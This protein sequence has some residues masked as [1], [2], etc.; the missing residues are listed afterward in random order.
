MSAGLIL[1]AWAIE[2]AFGY[3]QKLVARIGHPVVW[4][5]ALIT[6]LDERIDRNRFTPNRQRYYGIALIVV[7]LAVSAGLAQ[8]ICAILPNSLLGFTLEAFIASSLLAS[9]SLYGH[10]RAVMV[11][12]KADDLSGARGAVAM[13]VGRDVL[14]LDEAGVARAAI[15]SLSENASDGVIAPLFWGSIFGLPGLAAY[16]AINTM[17]SMIGHKTTKHLYVGWAAARL[18][19]LANWIPAR[20][21]GLLIGLAAQ[22]NQVRKAALRIMLKDAGHHRSP[23]AGWPEAAMAGVLGVRLSGPR[24]YAEAP[25]DD[26]W[27][28]ASG[29]DARVDSLEAA[30]IIYRRAMALGAGF[31]AVFALVGMDYH[32]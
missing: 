20:L 15:E 10:V 29:T 2:V 24:L 12:L 11:P 25:S 19:D 1:L 31:L 16:K 28:N 26:P 14:A 21:T 18:D 7:V 32:G 8:T 5:G 17:D 3:S 4:M 13:I 30:L 23:N 27:L 6:A 9:R 22:T